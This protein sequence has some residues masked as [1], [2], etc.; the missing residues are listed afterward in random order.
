MVE[1]H[2]HTVFG[3]RGD[4]VAYEKTYGIVFHCGLWHVVVNG[5]MT[6]LC[7][8]REDFALAKAKKFARACYANFTRYN[9]GGVT[10]TFKLIAYR[11]VYNRLP[12]E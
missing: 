4:V 12:V 6:N 10:F 8:K 1:C 7:Y 5:T 2:T 11:S 3:R 9:G